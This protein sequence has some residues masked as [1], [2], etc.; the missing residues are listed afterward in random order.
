M[1]LES[2]IAGIKWW[3][4]GVTWAL[5]PN[6]GNSGTAFD[7]YQKIADEKIN[8]DPISRST[9]SRT[10]CCCASA[11]TP[12]IFSA[13]RQNRVT[14]AGIWQVIHLVFLAVALA[15]IPERSYSQ[16][17]SLSETEIEYFGPFL[18]R[19][20]TDVELS[21]LPSTARD[22]VV[23]KVRLIV[24]P[25]YIFEPDR[26]EQDRGSQDLFH[27]RVQIV[28]PVKGWSEIGQEYDTYFGRPGVGRRYKYPA[29]LSEIG[30]HYFV[31]L[32]RSHDGQRRL[33]T[34][35]IAKSEFEKWQAESLNSKL[36]GQ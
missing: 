2:V 10:R 28:E 20:P 35:R 15:F 12:P 30:R 16:T 14:R 19:A 8:S 26:R 7:V 29:A 9:I 32:F 11:L 5:A 6:F 22:I 23:A 21:Q 3:S 27:A 34:P 13:D 33:L 4:S 36:N 18:D 17:T 24:Q 25:H 1:S 31:V